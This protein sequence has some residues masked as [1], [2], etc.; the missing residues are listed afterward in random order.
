MLVASTDE[1]A[2]Q[3]WTTTQHFLADAQTGRGRLLQPP[4]EPEEVGTEPDRAFIA[5][6]FQVKATGSPGTVRQHLEKFSERSGADELMVVTYTY[7]PEDR[8]RSMELLAELWFHECVMR[9]GPCGGRRDRAGLDLAG[10]GR[11]DHL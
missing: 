8:K 5:S 9:S 4:V 11:A 1:E 7:D 2:Q 3:I 10:A 6:M